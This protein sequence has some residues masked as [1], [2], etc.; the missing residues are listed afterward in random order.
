M[1]SLIA[2]MVYW[3]FDHLC[4]HIKWLERYADPSPKNCL[5]CQYNTWR[6]NRHF[7]FSLPE[8]WVQ[9]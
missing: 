2:S 5:F 7:G 8:E 1:A 4:I 3:S 9:T 6:I